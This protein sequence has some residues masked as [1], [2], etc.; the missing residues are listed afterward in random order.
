V[1][2]FPAQ[3]SLPTVRRPSTRA[4]ADRA[5]ASD[6]AVS[7]SRSPFRTRSASGVVAAGLLVGLALASPQAANAIHLTTFDLRWDPFPP[8]VVTISG[9]IT[10]DLDLLAA[11]PSPLPYQNDLALPAWLH[12]LT[13]HVTGAG[14]ASGTFTKSDYIGLQWNNNNGAIT[15]DFSQD[16]IGQGGWGTSCMAPYLGV[17]TFLL[18]PD[19]AGPNAAIAPNGDAGFQMATAGQYAGLTSFKPAPVPAPL[20]IVGMAS[21]LHWS[22]RLRR[23]CHGTLPGASASGA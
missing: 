11:V 14:P 19:P 6:G 13:L 3:C 18:K 8:H 9:Q 21:L 15:Y 5:G 12:D 17:C 10:L 20:P 7:R 2:S 22:R 4:C 23:R 16:L 1:S